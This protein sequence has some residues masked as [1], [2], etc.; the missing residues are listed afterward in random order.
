VPSSSHVSMIQEPLK[1]DTLVS[2][3]GLLDS[4]ITTIE[5]RSSSHNNYN[6]NN[7]KNK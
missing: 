2:T 3:Q 4:Y 5:S 1:K 7:I 6:N